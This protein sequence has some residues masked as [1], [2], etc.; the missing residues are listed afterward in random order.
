MSMMTLQQ[1]AQAMT[2]LLI[3]ADTTFDSVSTDSRKIGTGELFVAL[4][5]EKF[6]GHDFVAMVRDAGCV[7]AVIDQVALETVGGLGLPLIVVADTRLALGALAAAWR[8]RFAI[9]VIAVTGSNGNTT[10]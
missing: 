2:G 9:P 4:R 7:A 10:T 8:L 1:A 3:G 6:D 5:G